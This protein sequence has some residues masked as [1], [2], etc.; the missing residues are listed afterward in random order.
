MFHSLRFSPMK[1]DDLVTYLIKTLILPKP[2]DNN[3]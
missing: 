2:K 1:S 3:C